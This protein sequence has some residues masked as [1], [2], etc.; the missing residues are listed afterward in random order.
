MK[1]QISLFF[2]HSHHFNKTYKTCILKRGILNK[3]IRKFRK[4]DVEECSKIIEVCVNQSKEISK[5]AKNNI[6]SSS[7]T[8]EL[9]ERMK[10]RD[11]F[12]CE[13]NGKILGIGALNKNQVRT[14]YILPRY[15]NKGIGTLIL[16][17]IEKEAKR[18]RIKKLFLHTYLKAPKFFLKNNFNIVK[19]IK[20]GKFLV[21][22]MEKE[23]I[24]I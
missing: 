12:I 23:L 15:Q 7:T 5:R 22:Y 3:M 9:I 11:Y 14:M 4:K 21:T 2:T 16:K 1:K 10:R 17:R 8:E 20:H 19:K 18:R 24:L 6:K 13:K